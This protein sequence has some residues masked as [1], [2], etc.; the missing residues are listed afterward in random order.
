MDN[1]FKS[2]GTIQHNEKIKIY[3]ESDINGRLVIFNFLLSRPIQEWKGA[4]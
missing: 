4:C 3:W 1:I 2:D